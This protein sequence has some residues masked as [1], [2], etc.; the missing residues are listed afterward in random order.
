MLAKAKWNLYIKVYTQWLNHVELQANGYPDFDI[1]FIWPARTEDIR[2]NHRLNSLRN[3]LSQTYWPD[4][5]PLLYNLTVRFWLLII[6]RPFRSRNIVDAWIVQALNQSLSSQ[7][8]KRLKKNR[9]GDPSNKS[10]PIIDPD[11]LSIMNHNLYL[12]SFVVIFGK[13][14]LQSTEK[15]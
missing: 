3:H 14:K 9:K 4:S 12:T 5:L 15:F 13:I 8:M 10:D 1:D 11:N 2:S 6:P 7:F